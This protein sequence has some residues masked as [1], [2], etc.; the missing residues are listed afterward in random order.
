MKSSSTCLI[1]VSLCEGNFFYFYAESPS[2][3]FKHFLESTAVILSVMCL[4]QNFRGASAFMFCST[5]KGKQ[6]TTLSYFIMSITIL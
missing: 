6:D 2:P 1:T 5:N 3:N 4:S